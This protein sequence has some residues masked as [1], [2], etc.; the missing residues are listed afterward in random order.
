MNYIG[1]SDLVEEEKIGEKSV[2]T[3]ISKFCSIAPLPEG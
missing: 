1:K 2:K 3:K